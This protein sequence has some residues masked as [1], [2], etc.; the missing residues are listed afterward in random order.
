MKA[1][2]MLAYRTDAPGLRPPE[3]IFWRNVVFI[4]TCSLD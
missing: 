1:M 4:T 3:S 2:K